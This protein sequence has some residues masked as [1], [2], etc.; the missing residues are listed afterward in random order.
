MSAP[1]RKRKIGDDAFSGVQFEYEGESIILAISSKNTPDTQ[2]WRGTM[3]SVAAFPDLRTLDL[4]KNR[5]ITF[6][7]SSLTTLNQLTILDLTQCSR[8][9]AL[10]EDIGAL[11][12][13]EVLNLSDCEVF[14]ALPDSIGELKS[15]KQLS[16]ASPVSSGNK[17][18]QRLPESLG[19][20]TQLEVE[21]LI[22]A[23]C[24]NL[25]SLPEDA[26]G[27]LQSLSWLDLRNCK[28]LTSLPASMGNLSHLRQLDLSA[29]KSLKRLPDSLAQLKDRL[30][31]LNVSNCTSLE[32]IPSA[33]VCIG[34][35]IIGWPVE[36]KKSEPTS[37][38]D[39][40]VESEDP[41]TQPAA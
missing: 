22:L 15:L 9:Q 5:Y 4:H 18:L 31:V 14:A 30:E 19:S 41:P 23:K 7:H 13:L 28:S 32:E 25:V 3:P 26:I 40:A 27:D 29:C 10:P 2:R 33:L 38:S 12:S 37:T 24:K 35:V 36:A 34:S 16:L 11:S 39:S 1:T 6:L 8:L 21:D 20:L 17:V